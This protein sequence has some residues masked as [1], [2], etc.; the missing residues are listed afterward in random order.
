LPTRS[1]R[2][3]RSP[4]TA[5]PKAQPKNPRRPVAVAITGGI[6]AGKSEALRAFARRGAATLASDEIVHRL[7][8]EDEEVR[9]ALQDRFGTTDRG[10]IAAIVFEDREE[11]AWL[12][13][14]LHPRVQTEYAR[15]YAGL[16]EGGD[17]PA[18]AVVE[19]PLLYETG[20]EGRF[21]AVVAVTAPE[22]VRAARTGVRPDA[23]GKRLL[24]DEEKVRRA[25]FAYVNDGTLERLDAF[26][27]DVVA[28]LTAA[29]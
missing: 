7:I 4:A 8:A 27:G 11:L 5:L 18:L 29:A 17:P 15:W 26:V 6:G 24:P 25:N 23:R 12:E 10:A 20:S 2:R 19:I 21:D 13:R 9:T 3:H 14:L 28:A 22:A 1:P 16:A